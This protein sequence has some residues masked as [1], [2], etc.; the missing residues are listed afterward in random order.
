MT[1]MEIVNPIECA[2]CHEVLF[3][4]DAFEAHLARSHAPDPICPQCGVVV[5]LVH[6]NRHM[7]GRH[8]VKKEATSPP[9]AVMMTVPAGS[10]SELS[11]PPAREPS[12][13][14]DLASL[15]A[16]VAAAEDLINQ[17]YQRFSIHE[18]RADAHASPG[19]TLG[20]H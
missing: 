13:P 18:R 2:L 1:S 12:L 7:W 6:Y 5:P 17:L 3:T 20:V 14:D 8:K 19:S 10:L 9:P 11:L 15:E 4:M 16:R